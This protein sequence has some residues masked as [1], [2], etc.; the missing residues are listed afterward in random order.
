MR[1]LIL[2]SPLRRATTRIFV[3]TRV[4]TDAAGAG[5]IRGDDL[6]GAVLILMG[7]VLNSFTNVVMERFL[8]D[9]VDP[10]PPPKLACLCGIVSTGRYLLFFL[11]AVS[12]RAEALTRRWLPPSRFPGLPWLLPLLLGPRARLFP[13]PRPNRRR[14]LWRGEGTQDGELCL[15][16]APRLLRP[17]R[18]GC[19]RLLRPVVTTAA[20]V[21]CV[22]GVLALCSHEACLTTGLE[23]GGNKGY[24]AARRLSSSANHLG[25][26]S[27][28]GSLPL[29]HSSELEDPMGTSVTKMVGPA[30][31]SCLVPQLLSPFP[32]RH[33]STHL[34][35]A[36]GD[37][38][39]RAEG[40]PRRVRPGRGG[41]FA[42]WAAVRYLSIQA[43]SC[44][45]VL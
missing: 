40:F 21:L 30:G 12:W 19:S 9:D 14:E 44:F 18:R 32:H 15:S 22:G 13:A 23:L 36:N 39:G 1:L 29:R 5:S 24:C 7:S 33:T 37:C 43:F 17:R 35:V 42:G 16:V 3:D 2:P 11:S 38:G 27:G 28:S 34:I 26:E 8:T 10:Q 6:V 20:S 31:P 4:R 25:T 45:H 41:G